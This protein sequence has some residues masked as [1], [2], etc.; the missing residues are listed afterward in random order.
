MNRK[1]Q[2]GMVLVIGLVLVIILVIII[3]ISFLNKKLT[4]Q[5]NQVNVSLID[6][7]IKSINQ[8]NEIINTNYIL[9]SNNSIVS[10]GEISDW[11]NF[12]VDSKN[13]YNLYCWNEEHY[14]SNFSKKISNEEKV[15]NSSK[16]ICNLSKIGTLNVNYL[17]SI[18][19]KFISLNI[20]AIDTFKDLTICES[21]TIGIIRVNMLGLYCS[22]WN[23]IYGFQEFQYF[24]KTKYYMPIY[25]PN[26]LR[27]CGDWSL[28]CK[29]F[30]NSRC[31]IDESS[32]PNRLKNKVDTC[33]EIKKDLKDSGL[34][35]QFNLDTFNTNQNDKIEFYILDKESRLIDG[36]LTKLNEINSEN[37]WVDIGAKDKIIEVK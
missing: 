16:L 11:T 32:T 14:L 18:E 10:Q 27:I 5:E 1:A 30:E 2:L 25:Y 4:Q 7:Y 31:F 12:L 26:N 19:S 22:Y 35:I 15:L 13:E 33:W 3:S 9:T 29:I 17:G 6:L 8:D 20:S 24:N 23:N 34:S 28:N 37:T 21:H 36:N